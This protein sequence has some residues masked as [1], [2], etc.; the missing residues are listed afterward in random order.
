[1]NV[2]GP[3]RGSRS[4][5]VVLRPGNV[6]RKRKKLSTGGRLEIRGAV[7]YLREPA[8]NES[9]QPRGANAE[10]RELG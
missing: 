2:H 1:M 5:F 7:L 10:T 9:G 6:K 3:S 4:T 8:A